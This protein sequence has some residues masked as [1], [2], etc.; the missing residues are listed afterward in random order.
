MGLKIEAGKQYVTRDGKRVRIYATDGR[1]A[2]P[3]HG[4]VFNEGW[5]CA[6]EWYADGRYVSNVRLPEYESAMDLVAEYD[7]RQEI[8]WDHIHPD[9]KW[10]ARSD[11]D[12]F[13]CGFQ[14]RPSPDHTGRM[15][16]CTGPWIGLG[17][18]AGMPKGPEDWRDT[19][20]ARP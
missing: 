2:L 5:W 19:L 3:V 16:L 12:A 13:F 17:G 11:T 20:A 1:G 14:K 6:T 18:V 4:A 15:W 10:I 8:P 9:L 7:W